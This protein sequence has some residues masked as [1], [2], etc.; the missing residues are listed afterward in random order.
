MN[1]QNYKNHR[2]FYAPHHFIYLP[3]LL[4]LFG[5]GIY[6]RSADEE[7]E[8]L[9]T[10]FSGIIF[11]ILYLAIMVRQHYALVLQDR[12]VVIEFRQRYFEL[13]SKRSDEIVSQLNFSQIA[14]LRFAYDDEFKTLIER[15]LNENISGDEIK[16]SITNWRPDLS[17]V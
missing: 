15:A 6:K 14:A 11:L 16:K 2:K 5:Y 12:M 13:F 3:A 7:N 1:A 10:L 4:V 9:W 8:L 17:R